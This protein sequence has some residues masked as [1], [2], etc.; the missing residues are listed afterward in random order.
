ML[1]R[2]MLSAAVFILITTPQLVQA[3]TITF[4]SAITTPN[5]GQ[6]DSE[7]GFFDQY[8]PTTLGGVAF[9]TQGFTFGT[10]TNPVFPPDPDSEFVILN[11]GGC[12]TFIF[13]NCAPG[14]GKY[15]AAGGYAFGIPG[16]TYSLS[17][18][19][20][21]KIFPDPGCTTCGDPGSADLIPNPTQIQ[22]TGFLAGVMVAQETFALTTSFQTF[23]LT[24]PD[25]ANVV[26]TVVGFNGFGGI[27]NIVVGPPVPEPTTLLLLGTGLAGFAAR[28]RTK[29]K[30]Q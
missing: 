22:V 25:W 11:P 26:R 30:R 13:V 20:A 19:Q 5:A 6:P 16:E 28:R 15:L 14:D 4:D 10:F 27:D 8:E 18:F 9:Q 2:L 17:S 24:D 3:E 7:P 23:V 12:P 29:S 21:T 1:R